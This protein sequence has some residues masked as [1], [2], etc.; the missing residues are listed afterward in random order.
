MLHCVVIIVGLDTSRDVY[1]VL[2]ITIVQV[3]QQRIHLHRCSKQLNSKT[4]QFLVVFLS[5]SSANVIGAHLCAN[6][7]ASV[8]VRPSV[9]VILDDS[10]SQSSVLF[11]A[12]RVATPPDSIFVTIVA[13]C[14]SERVGITFKEFLVSMPCGAKR[15]QRTMDNIDALP[16]SDMFT[17]KLRYLLDSIDEWRESRDC[18]IWGSEYSRT[19]VFWLIVTLCYMFWTVWKKRFLFLLPDLF[20]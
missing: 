19:S 11:T 20:T 5:L 18:A 8:L 17:V 10:N 9:L 14:V 12:A 15:I 3:T 2:Y 1:N 13:D 6:I 7:D 4:M 16:G